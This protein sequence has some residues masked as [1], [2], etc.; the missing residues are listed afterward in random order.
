MTTVIVIPS[1]PQQCPECGSEKIGGSLN[2][3]GDDGN[4]LLCHGCGVWMQIGL[5]G[6]IRVEGLELTAAI[7]ICPHC[8]T[9]EAMGE[10]GGEE[11]CMGCGLNPNILDY[12]SPTLSHLWRKDSDIQRIMQ[13]GTRVLR[14]DGKLGKFLR[15]YCGPHCPFAKDCPQTTGNLVTCYKEECPNTSLGGDMGRKSRR[16]KS[17]N[18]NKPHKQR[19]KERRQER[20]AI[21]R[22]S[23]RALMECPKSSWFTKVLY[24]NSPYPEQTGNTGGGSGT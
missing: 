24:D 7:F 9:A 11:W 10:G 16:R 19:K 13:K 12:P 8:K 3:A 22:A 4:T 18:S 1:V 20:E 14:P 15:N 23:R 2:I 21:L 5:T 17:G 6:E